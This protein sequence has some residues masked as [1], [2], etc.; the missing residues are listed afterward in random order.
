[1]MLGIVFRGILILRRDLSENTN[2][3]INIAYYV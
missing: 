3:S 1:M 2:G